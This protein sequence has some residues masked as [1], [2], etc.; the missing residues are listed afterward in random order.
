MRSQIGSSVLRSLPLV[1]SVVLYQPSHRT[2]SMPR[3]NSSK[4]T[5]SFAYMRIPNTLWNKQKATKTYGEE[6]WMGRY[7]ALLKKDALRET[8]Y[9]R[10]LQSKIGST[11]STRLN[12][13]KREEMR[14]R[15]TEKSQEPSQIDYIMDKYGLTRKEAMDTLFWMDDVKLDQQASSVDASQKDSQNGKSFDIASQKDQSKSKVIPVEKN[16]ASNQRED[17]FWKFYLEE[18]QRLQNQNLLYRLR[19]LSWDIRQWCYF[20]L[21]C[22]HYRWR[23]LRANWKRFTSFE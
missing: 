14:N 15:A 10:G 11:S 3:K 20:R 23:T 19:N 12:T 4:E 5:S 13:R 16:N 6:F 1:S 21:L 7:H 2:F 18:C 9:A 17:E 8:S 22:F